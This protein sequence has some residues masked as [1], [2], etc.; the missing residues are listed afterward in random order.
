MYELV[1]ADQ[2]L[3]SFDEIPGKASNYI[4]H[5]S[6]SIKPGTRVYLVCRVRD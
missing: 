6:A 5:A 3:A 2:W 1:S 4:A